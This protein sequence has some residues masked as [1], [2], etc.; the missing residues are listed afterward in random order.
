MKC[1][2]ARAAFLS[3][4]A[5]RMALEHLAACPDCRS[6]EE[7]LLQVRTILDDDGFW[8]PPPSDLEQR[9][10]TL[11]GG[12]PEAAVR[13]PRRSRWWGRSTA[14]L[15]V[16]AVVVV[17]VAWAGLRSPAADW[18]VTIPGTAEAPLASGVVQGWNEPGGTRLSLD[19]DGLPPAPSGYVYEF[20]FTSGPEHI[21]AGTFSAAGTV[22]LW[23]GVRRADYPRLWITLEPLDGDADLTGVNVM[24][25]G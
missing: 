17:V 20:W 13:T 6:Q 16:A 11:I 4:E 12:A 14:W 8:E 22:D 25:T 7:A 23:V 24:D 1:E 9:V 2:E 5:G 18:E 10:V 15:G 19:I 21:S 3:G